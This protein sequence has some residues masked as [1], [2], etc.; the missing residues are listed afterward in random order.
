[1]QASSLARPDRVAR[2]RLL[3]LSALF[4]ALTAV[5]SWIS[6]PLPFSPVPINLATLSV[7]L[8]G[9]LLGPAG[10]AASQAVFVA[11][12][13][14]G[15]PVFHSFTGGVGILAGP[16][17]GYL[18]GYIAAAWIAGTGFATGRAQTDPAA[19]S[20]IQAAGRAQID[21]AAGAASTKPAAAVNKKPPLYRGAAVL[22][23]A[24]LACYS[25]GTL[26]FMLSTGTGLAAAL[27]LCV[28]PFLPGDAVK[29]AAALLLIRK[30][31]PIV[32]RPL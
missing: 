21:P 13:A 14:V 1:M 4:A 18:I 10:G 26:W 16:T 19:D 7:F 25:L 17:G 29:I 5:G 22:A 9:G 24:L 30:L 23:V 27:L 8:A 15:L 32:R 31:A 28:V 12:G 20:P 6:I 2:T 11:L 3:I